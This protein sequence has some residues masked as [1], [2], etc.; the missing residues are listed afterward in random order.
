MPGVVTDQVDVGDVTVGRVVH[1]PGWRWSTHIKPHVGGEWCQARHVGVIISGRI[2]VVF[3][4]G[5][6]VEFGP[7]DVYEIPP[8]HD[9]YV[10]G[11]EP[12]VC[13]EWAGLRTFTGFQ[14]GGAGRALATLLFLDIAESTAVAS[15]LGDA[16]W[17]ELLS[18]YFEIARAELERCHGREVKTTGDGLLATFDGPAQALRCAAAIRRRS[19]QRD[20]QLRAGV[21]VGEVELVGGDIRGAAVHEAARIMEHAEPGETLVSETTRA[22]AAASGFEFQE[23]GKHDLRGLPDQWSLFAHRA[24]TGTP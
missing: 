16:A 20:L 7:D 8:G 24:E 21:H 11:H 3:E 9:G 4:D 5:T 19:A 17:R 1:E 2:G 13:L 22:L 23:R 15:R 14:G 18:D 10:I 6:T 12:C